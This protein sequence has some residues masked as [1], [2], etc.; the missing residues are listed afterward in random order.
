M[1]SKVDNYIRKTEAIIAQMTEENKAYFSDLQSYMLLSSLIVDENE[2]REQIYSMAL[3]LLE[4]EKN[5]MTAE[6]YFGKNPKELADDLIKQ[7]KPE[8][9]WKILGLIVIITFYGFGS[10]SLYQFSNAGS[11]DINVLSFFIFGILGFLYIFFLFYLLKKSIY[12]QFKKFLTYVVT[13]SIFV[14]FIVLAFILK[15]VNQ[16]S[17]I[18][19][20][21]RPYDLLLL[22]GFL[23]VILFSSF[24]ISFFRP[25]FVV[26]LSLFCSG[27]IKKYYLLGVLQGEL[28]QR[29]IP[30]ALLV[31]SM[32][33]F[34]LWLRLI[35]K[36]NS[37]GE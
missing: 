19:T 18:I 22:S 21:P 4:A 7:A 28:W 12:T 32:I 14:I 16:F 1:T 31:I 29:W 30:L 11:L 25:V 2:I 5:K 23:F 26:A 13:G 17:Y 36:K 8:S 33:V 27:V 20:I 10:F 9:V 15:I 6:S 37:Q 24:K 34:Y 3:D 35:L